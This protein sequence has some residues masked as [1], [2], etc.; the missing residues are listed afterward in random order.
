MQGEVFIPEINPSNQPVANGWQWPKPNL[1]R[2]QQ[3]R[4]IFPP[5]SAQSTDTSF[6]FLE[7]QINSWRMWNQSRLIKKGY[8]IHFPFLLWPWNGRQRSNFLTPWPNGSLSEITS[9]HWQRIGSG[10]C[11]QKALGSKG[12]VVFS[13]SEIP[14]ASSVIMQGLQ[15]LWVSKE[16]LKVRD[17]VFSTN[18]PANK[19]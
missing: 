4:G 12:A 2:K 16:S 17:Q 10:S 1:Y 15:G 9:L 18:C 11:T 14:S 13:R 7:K 5:P 6:F 19:I 8:S 3:R